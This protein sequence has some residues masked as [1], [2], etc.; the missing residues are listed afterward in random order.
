[1]GSPRNQTL[2]S[3]DARCLRLVVSVCE[4]W[5]VGVGTIERGLCRTRIRVESGIFLTRR[6]LKQQDTHR[7]VFLQQELS[8]DP[9]EHTPTQF[10]FSSNLALHD[11][12]QPFL[13]Q[14]PNTPAADDETHPDRF[15][16]WNTKHSVPY[17]RHP[18]VT[19]R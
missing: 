2:P 16:R 1:M 9:Q 17:Y 3:R 6:D 11:L 12:A 15:S 5:R 8:I 7:L 18:A 14:D 10:L 19:V 13:P 4:F